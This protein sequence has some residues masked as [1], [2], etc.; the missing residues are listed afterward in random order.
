[1][2]IQP[3]C[4]PLHVDFKNQV[5]FHGAQNISGASHDEQRSFKQLK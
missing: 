4:I 2:T 5:K 3:L 1:M